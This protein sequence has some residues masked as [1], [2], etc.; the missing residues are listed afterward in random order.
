MR[1]TRFLGLQ[2]PLVKTPRGILAQKSGIDQIKA[3]MLQ[4]LLTNPGER[5]MLPTFG[6]PLRKLMFEPN[7]P[8]LEIEARN[9]IVAALL[10]WE[11]RVEIQNVS[12]SCV[13][14]EDDLD[15]NDPN[16]DNEHILSIKIMFYDP[17]NIQKIE[18]LAVALPY[19]GG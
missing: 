10:Q 1:N 18:E 17:Q 14:N 4:L 6:T 12:V 8:T 5:V 9:M 3:D 11:K 15:P 13:V 7:D 2:Y 19:N 16:D